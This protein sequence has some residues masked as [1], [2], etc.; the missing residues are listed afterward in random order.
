M[1]T[2]WRGSGIKANEQSEVRRTGK[3]PNGIENNDERHFL[4]MIEQ[5]CVIGDPVFGPTPGHL[6]DSFVST[7]GNLPSKKLPMS[8]GWPGL[9]RGGG[10]PLLEFTVT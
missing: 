6:T 9:G 5:C 1:Y 2:I 3:Q 8:V 4:V 10:W 7:P